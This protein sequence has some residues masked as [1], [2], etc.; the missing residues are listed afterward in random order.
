MA[1]PLS[2]TARSSPAMAFSDLPNLPYHLGSPLR[3]FQ[4]GMVLGVPISTGF[5]V[6]CATLTGGW[7]Q[8]LLGTFGVPLGIYVGCVL[9]AALLTTVFGLI[10]TGLHFGWGRIFADRGT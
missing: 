10:G 6:T 5:A 8:N 1:A 2:S 3:G 9:G 7:G 4:A